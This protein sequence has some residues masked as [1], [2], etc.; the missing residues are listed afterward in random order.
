MSGAAG[1]RR[2]VGRIGKWR[3]NVLAQ[4]GQRPRVS[5]YKMKAVV[6]G[7]GSAC[8]LCKHIANRIEPID[9]QQKALITTDFKPQ[10]WKGNQR[11]VE[12]DAHPYEV[13]C[14]PR[15]RMAKELKDIEIL[16]GSQW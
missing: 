9:R 1:L 6:P 7:G 15:S 11:L 12:N 2:S 13:V 4:V 16:R 5:V 3:C 8:R 10:V 14:E